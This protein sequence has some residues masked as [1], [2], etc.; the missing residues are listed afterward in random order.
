MNDTNRTNNEK[1]SPRY[2]V[3]AAIDES[4]IV[5][6]V[7]AQAAAIA[8]GT[9]G[10]E[11]HILHAALRAAEADVT[12]VPFDL[13]RHRRYLDERARDTQRLAG[14]PVVGHLVE[15]EPADAILQIAAGIDA[16]LVVVGT[17]DKRGPALWLLG[18]V[19]QKVAHRAACPVLVVRP[20]EH[21][22]RRSPEIEPP[23]PDCLREQRASHGATLWCARHAQHHPRM[24]LHYEAVQGFG[25][26][27]SLLRP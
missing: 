4:P 18:S 6:K 12:N 24:H 2:V 23:C 15:E 10:A 3:L 9:A 5:A 27:S 8:A 21:H 11:L 1:P 7:L 14:V 13:E 22:V 17:S 19:A 20:K 16:D 25:A 26:G